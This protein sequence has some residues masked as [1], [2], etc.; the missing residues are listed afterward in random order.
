MR[1]SWDG[2]FRETE[3]ERNARLRQKRLALT[4]QQEVSMFYV[5]KWDE[6]FGWQNVLTTDDQGE[7]EAAAER[8]CPKGEVVTE[9]REKLPRGYFGS[10]NGKR[11]SARITTSP[12]T[13][14]G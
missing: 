7:A 9:P 12:N 6:M 4:K 5:Q 8:L 11:W 10:P 1:P 14:F 3:G 13:S 2:Q